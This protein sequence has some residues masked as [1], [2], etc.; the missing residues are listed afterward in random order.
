[1]TEERDVVSVDLSTEFNELVRYRSLKSWQEC[2]ECIRRFE[3][4]TGSSYEICDCRVYR[5]ENNMV[6]PAYKYLYVV[7]CCHGDRRKKWESRQRE[8]SKSKCIDCLFTF[9]IQLEFGQYKVAE[10]INT[11]HNHAL[12]REVIMSV[13]PEIPKLRSKQ[14]LQVLPSTERSEPRAQ[15]V[16][17]VDVELEN[18]MTYDEYRHFHEIVYPKMCSLDTLISEIRETGTVWYKMDNQRHVEKFSFATKEMITLYKK[19]PE[20]VGMNSMYITNGEG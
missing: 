20:V 18:H 4:K 8:R 12:T 17:V 2:E 9:R 10:P 1:M 16:N 6:D 7:F 14:K 3:E 13:E 19:F 5:N 15:K 11:I